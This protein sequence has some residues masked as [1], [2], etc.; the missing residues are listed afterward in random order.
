VSWD[1]KPVSEV[2]LARSVD[3]LEI[4]A[5]PCQFLLFNPCAGVGETLAYLTGKEMLEHVR[6][7]SVGQP[8]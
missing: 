8:R 3:V 1:K 4:R 2:V 5:T 7:W 6:R